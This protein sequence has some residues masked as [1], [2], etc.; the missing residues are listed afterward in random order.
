MRV[1]TTSRHSQIPAGPPPPSDIPKLKYP[2]M[3]SANRLRSLYALAFL[4]PVL[5]RVKLHTSRV[6]GE[7]A[8]RR[9]LPNKNHATDAWL[10]GKG[11]LTSRK[12]HMFL[13]AP[14]YEVSREMSNTVKRAP[15]PTHDSN[16]RR[17]HNGSYNKTSSRCCQLLNISTSLCLFY[18]TAVFP[19]FHVRWRYVPFLPI[20]YLSSPKTI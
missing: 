19:A 3:S 7:R 12:V 15:L 16:L 9:M 17:G 20:T 2:Q 18:G 6:F 11:G 4:R 13:D 10:R 8:F 14:I 1:G 5:C